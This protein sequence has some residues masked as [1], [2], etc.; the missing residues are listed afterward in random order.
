M[1]YLNEGGSKSGEGDRRSFQKAMEKNGCKSW[2]CGRILKLDGEAAC[3]RETEEGALKRLHNNR[4]EVDN[5]ILRTV[6][7][8]SWRRCGEEDPHKEAVTELTVDMKM[9]H[10]CNVNET[11][12]Q[13]RGCLPQ[14]KMEQK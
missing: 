4:K 8:D 9:S 10:V 12:K 1:P 7:T 13:Q 11:L 2:S 5:E 6:Y 14:R 3:L